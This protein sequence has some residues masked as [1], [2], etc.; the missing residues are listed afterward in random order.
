M[1]LSMTPQPPP[2]PRAGCRFFEGG[3]GVRGCL[4]LGL[5]LADA[6]RAAFASLLNAANELILAVTQKRNHN[7][8][9]PKVAEPAPHV[10]GL[11]FEGFLQCRSGGCRP[12]Q[13]TGTRGYLMSSLQ[14]NTATMRIPHHIP[15]G[16]L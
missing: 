4:K 1:I 9:L 6:C 8:M 16:Q 15:L 11:G 14:G 5:F 12:C 2:L 10:V 3:G 13:S 7:F